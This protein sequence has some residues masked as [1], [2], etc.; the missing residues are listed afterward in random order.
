MNHLI[1]SLIAVQ[2]L[3]LV[4]C[5]SSSHTTDFYVS[6]WNMENL[7]DLIDDP[8]KRD[9]EWLEGESKGWSEERLAEKLENLS[10][11]IRYM[12][13]GEGP[14][15]LGFQEVEHR[16]LIDTLISRHLKNKNYSVAYIESPD[17]RG[18]DNG[19][20]YNDEM[21][22]L[23]EVKS[24]T[25]TLQDNYP[26]R[27]IVEASFTIDGEVKIYLFVN[28]WPSRWG[29]QEKSEPNR[30]SAAEKLKTVI[31]DI[32]DSEDEAN[33]IIL[34]DFNDDPDNLSL[35][36]I[37]GAVEYDCNSKNLNSG[38]Y[39][40]NLSF[41]TFKNGEGSYLYRGTWN[42]L[43]QIIISSPLTEK[44]NFFYNCASFK[45]IR[46]EYMVTE[47]GRYKGAAKPTYGGRNY[48]GGFSDHYPVG[49]SFRF[50]DE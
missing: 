10:E 4:S 26:T 1:R 34:G 2:I 42:M 8:D 30:I 43:D 45:V 32:N 21:F 47:E 17:N 28:H 35:N 39:L 37:L 7:F 20:I 25:V 31:T 18:I 38:S 48:L 15:L 49:A 50:F 23:L 41:K 22:D 19:I 36:E 27:D 14:D 3:F 16:H 40:Y 46:P 5:S 9:S 6:S 13:N 24:H 44:G 33:I 11:V 12:N 29:G